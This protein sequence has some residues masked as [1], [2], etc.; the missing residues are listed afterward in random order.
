ML[1]PLSQPGTLGLFFS[2]SFS[3]VIFEII[4]QAFFEYV[5]ITNVTTLFWVTKCTSYI[6]FIF[7]KIF[8]ANN[9]G[10]LKAYV[11]KTKQ[12]LFCPSP[13]P[14]VFHQK[15]G[16]FLLVLTFVFLN[17]HLLTL[18][19]SVL[20]YLLTSYYDRWEFYFIAL[21]LLP[22]CQYHHLGKII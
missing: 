12:F 15:Q 22:A 14:A 3:Y 18:E 6:N 20:V 4:N 5:C 8:Y 19:S 7:I 11:Q 13:L 2:K 1:Q 21:L 9:K 16:L 17:N 10:N